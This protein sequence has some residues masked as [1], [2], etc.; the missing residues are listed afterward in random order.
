MIRSVRVL[1]TVIC[2]ATVLSEGL[3]V[4][5]LWMTGRLTPQSLNDMRRLLAGEEP[6]LD[7]S[8]AEAPEA[9]PPS[10]DDV[11]RQRTDRVWS[12]HRRQ[13]ELVTIK[14]MITQRAERL[15]DLREDFDKKRAAF[16][17]DLQRQSAELQSASAEQAR[18]ILKKLPPAD[19]VQD[20][21]ALDLDKDVLLLKG[22][23]DKDVARILQEFLKGPDDKQIER[24]KEIF[25]AISRGQPTRKI[26][27]AGLQQFAPSQNAST[28][29]P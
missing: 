1:I 6:E 21:M 14:D 20:L 2:A 9:T 3:F 22:M 13:E 5:Y 10:N 27:D 19:A 16:Q 8:R 11:V 17:Q 4:G 28:A 12:L 7:R 29:S 25:E 15:K 26:V 18:G 24:G 23:P